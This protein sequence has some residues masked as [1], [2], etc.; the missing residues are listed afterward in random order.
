MAKGYPLVPGAPVQRFDLADPAFPARL[1]QA[2]DVDRA[3]PDHLEVRGALPERP[4]AVAIV[5]A[6][7]AL[8]ADLE[9]ARRLGRAVAANDGVVV[10]GGAIGVD[11]AAHRGALDGGGPTIVVLG[12]GVDVDY[13]ARN[14]GL[15]AEVT[16]TGAVVSSFPRGTQPRPGN[17]VRRNAVIAALADAVVVIG[18]RAAS[19]SMH[20]AVAAHRLG[21]VVAASPG[22]EGGDRL[23]A[24]GAAVVADDD[25]LRA[26]LA[27]A[28]RR[29]VV[30]AP[31][32]GTD[33]ARAL[34]ALSRGEP[35]DLDEVA[36][37]TG[38]PIRAA[39]RALADLEL[40]GLAVLAPGQAY[41]RSS[42]API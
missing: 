25:D 7:A 31:D 33:A 2:R 15:F 40:R 27:G 17:F 39:L 16:R 28:P 12:T 20:T 41:L 8:T 23:I 37:R 26:L 42:L 21:R 9:L 6:R 5:G 3:L 11:S 14:R 10:S 22:S 30:A 34:D 32:P 18:A 36:A 13:P 19:G 24:S 4:A 29:P 1:R 35:R 38:L